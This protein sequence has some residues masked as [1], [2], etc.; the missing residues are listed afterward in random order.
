MSLDDLLDD[1]TGFDAEY[2]DG[3]SNHLPMALVALQ[4]LGAGDAQLQ[5]FAGTY[6]ARLQPAPPWQ[7]WPS[8]DAWPSRLGQREAWPAYRD[9]FA[10]WLAHEGVGDLLAQTLPVLMPGCGAAAFHG[11]I[12]TAYAVQAVHPASLVDGLAY[13]ACRHLSLGPL[14]AAGGERAERDPIVLLRQLA[15]RR[16]GSRL[17]FER[18]REAASDGRI[19]ATVG[20]LQVDEHTAQRLAR[21]AAFAYAGSGNFTALHLVT[22]GHALRTLMPFV[23]T[24]DVAWRWY[25]QAFAMAVAAADLQVLPPVPALSWDEIV[26]AAL[27]SDDDHLIKLVDSCREE[28][29]A[30]GGDDWRS[31]ASRAVQEAR[32]RPRG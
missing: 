27:A 21:A 19:N 18:M 13:W 5:R 25:W 30:Y 6:A 10:Q 3:L 8:G 9:L 2:G 20:A 11:L 24:A 32:D 23:D 29:A 17:I 1:A 16:S 31:A 12:R 28:E 26:A 7:A 14:D 22:S 15:A 4:R